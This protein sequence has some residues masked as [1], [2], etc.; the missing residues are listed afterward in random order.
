MS[1]A[2]LTGLIVALALALSL[3][4]VAEAQRKKKPPAVSAGV[5]EA[6]RALAGGD[7]DA[8][9]KAA[10]ILGKDRSQAGLDA[11][12]DGL[13]LGLHPQVATA[14]LD[15]LGAR[16]QAGA[17]D[18]LVAYADH[19]NP[20]VRARALAALAALDDKRTDKHILAAL[21]D[22]EVT[23]RA[24]G[25]AA[26]AQRKIRGGVEPLLVLLT[27]GDDASA[28]ALA[29]MA[30]PELARKVAETIGKA[31]N[32]VVARCLGAILARPSFKPDGARVEVVRALG[33]ID[34]PE[35]LEQL[36]TYVSSVPKNPPRQSRKEAE[37]LIQI[38]MDGGK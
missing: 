9:A 27:R 1:Y 17:L 38:K 18:T 29:A 32:P 2:R 14:A 33:Q 36:T 8:A 23:V 30:D 26:I 12:L 28:P 19:R 3:P 13:A 16:K 10:T 5:A 4:S 37:Q 22:G 25:A 6:A 21:R 7:I 31:P 35:A 15:A 20:K 34:G 24:A 11:L